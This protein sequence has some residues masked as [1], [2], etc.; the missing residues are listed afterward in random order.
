MF[1]A[2][3]HI[4][5][6]E[7]RSLAAIVH[8]LKYLVNDARSNGAQANFKVLRAMLHYIDNF[9]ERLHHPKEDAYLFAHLLKRTHEADAVIDELKAQHE[10]GARLVSALHT[11]LDAYEAGESGGLAAFGEAVDTFADA[12]WQH[13]A[14]E[15]KVLLPLA[16]Q[17]LTDADWVEIGQAFGDNGDPRFSA[18]AENEFSTLFSRIVTIAPPPIGV[19]PSSGR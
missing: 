5:Q 11:R 4:I 8:G 2:A 14:L 9:P 3:I 15:E 16:R 10:D 13:M 6:E 7:H 12:M 1:N 19:G 18:D 17:H